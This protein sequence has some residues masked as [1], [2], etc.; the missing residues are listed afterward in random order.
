MD[1]KDL[2]DL[3]KFK[4]TLDQN[5]YDEGIQVIPDN[6][7]DIIDGIVN[8]SLENEHRINAKTG[9]IL[10]PI[11]LWSLNKIKEYKKPV[12]DVVIMDKLDGVSCLLYKNKAYTRG[13]GIYGHDITNMINENNFKDIGD[14]AIRGELVI[15]KNKYK[16][17][18][19]EFSNTRTMVCSYISRNE[20]N[21]DI[22][23]VAYELI[24]LKGYDLKPSQQFLKLKQYGFHTVFN[25]DVLK[26]DDD[27]FKDVLK[28]RINESPYDIDGI[29]VTYENIKRKSRELTSNPKYSFAYKQNIKGV[30]TKIVDII[31]NVGKSGLYTP[32]I[33]IEPVEIAGTVIQKV[34]GYNKCYIMNRKIGKGSIVEV[35]KAGNVIPCISDVI[36]ESND[37][38]FP[39]DCD[40]KGVLNINNDDRIEACKLTHFAKTLKI[41]GIGPAKAKE[42]I[43]HGITP[44]SIVTQGTQG[45]GNQFNKLK[46]SENNK[47]I[48]KSI[49]EQLISSTP[50]D[51]LTALSFF[52]VGVARAK[53]TKQKL[54]EQE[55]AKILLNKWTSTWKPILKP[56]T[57]T[58]TSTCKPCKPFENDDGPTGPTD[59]TELC[60]IS[61]SRSKDV[62]AKV[63]K[64]GYVPKY[65]LV[66]NTKILFVVGEYNREENKKIKEALKRGIRI[67]CI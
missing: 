64:M 3:E 17:Y 67:K 9:K 7:Y 32:I 54:Y 47:K 2:K 52:G 39:T 45:T 10:L 18:S 5:Y 62:E 24:S 38:N 46:T 43:E 40:D 26:G 19:K 6:E 15:K 31:W 4:D 58:C 23:F 20:Y 48:I 63:I 35:I 51:I 65:N 55:D 41:Q 29:V 50:I 37:I 22:D 42:M 8:M 66:K 11:Q 44:M 30:P 33:V 28:T 16:K 21:D 13:N 34:S 49:N 14:N 59:H 36:T 1:L 27:T 12:D 57:S 56:L 61:G 25:T 53:I 60:C